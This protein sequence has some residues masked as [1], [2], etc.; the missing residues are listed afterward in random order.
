MRAVGVIPLAAMVTLGVAA[1]ASG[2]RRD[3][4]AAQPRRTCSIV[5]LR[6]PPIDEAMSHPLPDGGD[7]TMPILEPGCVASHEV[8]APRPSR[9]AAS[10]A[11]GAPPLLSPPFSVPPLDAARDGLSDS[12]RP[13]ARLDDGPAHP[14]TDG[15]AGALRRR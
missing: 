13:V 15:L 9:R 8:P 12:R 5:V 14:L 11:P 2:Q 1:A 3:R 4:D 10:P 7:L 6:V